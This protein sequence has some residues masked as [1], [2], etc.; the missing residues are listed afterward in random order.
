LE[1]DKVKILCLL[2]YSFANLMAC[3][4]LASLCFEPV[5]EQLFHVYVLLQ[6]I[7]DRLVGKWGGMHISW[8]AKLRGNVYRL[9]GLQSVTVNDL[10]PEL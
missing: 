1:K 7:T 3:F 10:L 4:L 9:P 6:N 2:T 5:C 8:R